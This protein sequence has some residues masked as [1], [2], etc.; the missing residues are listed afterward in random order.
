MFK[1]LLIKSK[2][3]KIDQSTWNDVILGK[4]PSH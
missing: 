3:T 1:K 2:C 4:M